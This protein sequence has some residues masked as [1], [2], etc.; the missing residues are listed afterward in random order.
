MGQRESATFR[1]IE[2]ALRLLIKRESN[3]SHN[4]GANVANEGGADGTPP[5]VP[6]EGTAEHDRYAQAEAKLEAQG[7]AGIPPEA[8]GF[9]FT[10]GG[11]PDPLDEGWEP[12]GNE[13]FDAL[14]AR[15]LTPDGKAGGVL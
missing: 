1:G 9:M 14:R 13:S 3:D 8:Q 2:R 11:K 10:P 12:L 7:R 5:L 15:H 4:H 6:K